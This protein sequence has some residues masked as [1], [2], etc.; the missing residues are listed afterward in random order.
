MPSAPAAVAAV[1]RCMA[2]L[3]QDIAAIRHSATSPGSRKGTSNAA[4][5]GLTAH[6][7]GSLLR[8]ID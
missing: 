8:A 6:L 4:G 7:A 5:A 1:A 3:A 2:L